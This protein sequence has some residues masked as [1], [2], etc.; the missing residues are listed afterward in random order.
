MFL[1]VSAFYYAPAFGG[2]YDLPRRFS[3]VVESEPADSL[4]VDM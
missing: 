2:L 3:A 4:S 1:Q